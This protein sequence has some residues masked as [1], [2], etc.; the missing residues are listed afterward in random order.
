MARLNLSHGDHDSHR[1]MISL[2]RD[3][4]K[5]HGR[6]VAILQDIQGPRIR[7]GT[8]PGATEPIPGSEVR[9]LLDPVQVMPV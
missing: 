7:V 9:L 3:A 6:A 4:A 5:E 2:V 8:F 1:R